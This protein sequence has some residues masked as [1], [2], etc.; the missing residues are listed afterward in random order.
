MKIRIR[1]RSLA[2]SEELL[3]LLPTCRSIPRVLA[4]TVAFVLTLAPGLLSA[5]EHANEVPFKLYRGYAIVARG[6]IGN[7]KNLNFLIDTGAVPSVLDRRIA[8]KLQ[9]TG[10]MEKLSVFTQKLAAER[11]IAHNVQ[12][13]TVRTDSL[14][15]VV[16]DLSFGESALGVRIDAMIGFDLLSQGPFVI[17]YQSK[18]LVFGP[19]D[20]SLPVIPYHSGP[21]YVAVEMRIQQKKFLLLVDTGASDLVLFGDTTLDCADAVTNIGRRTWSNMGGDIELN[22]VHLR[23]TYVGFISWES[24]DVFVLELDGRSKPAGLGGLLGVISLKARRLGF[25]P[26]RK[27]LVLDGLVIPQEP[28][29]ASREPAAKERLP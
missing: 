5:K 20:T 29:R 26:D 28:M 18:R 12:L 17:D 2:T 22:Q 7:L 24:R 10:T 4:L 3:W 1:V 25:D 8:D 6:S 11:V 16:R 27:V 23:D 15:V 19:I 9:L 13:G 21:G 14:P